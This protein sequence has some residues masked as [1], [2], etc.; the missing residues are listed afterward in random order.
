MKHETTTKINTMKLNT[1]EI[2]KR[3][4]GPLPLF[5]RKIAGEA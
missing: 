1:K 5:Q 2:L 4:W 3:A